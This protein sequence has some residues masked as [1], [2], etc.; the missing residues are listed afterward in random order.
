MANESE[1]RCYACV[2]GHLVGRMKDSHVVYLGSV[3][4]DDFL[5]LRDSSKSAV[6]SFDDFLDGFN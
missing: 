1:Q 3:H 2:N 4:L 6:D 5:S